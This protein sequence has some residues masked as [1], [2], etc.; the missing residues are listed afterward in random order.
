MC[1]TSNYNWYWYSENRRV[2]TLQQTSETV[3]AK[4]TIMQFLS[5]G[6]Q[7]EAL[8]LSTSP[9]GAPASIGLDF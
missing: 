9:N 8:P 5:Y 3:S 1:N 4:H 6:R 7:T 2:F